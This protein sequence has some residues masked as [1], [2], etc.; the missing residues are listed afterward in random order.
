MTIV[1][2]KAINKHTAVKHNAEHIGR[3]A[4]KQLKTVDL[5]IRHCG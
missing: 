2:I 1:F 4:K 3:Q 5:Q